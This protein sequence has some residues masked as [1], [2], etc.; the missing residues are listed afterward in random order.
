[1]APKASL[2]CLLFQI[3]AAKLLTVPQMCQNTVMPLP[4]PGSL[5]AMPFPPCPPGEQPTTHLL[6]LSS[7]FSDSREYNQGLWGSHQVESRSAPAFCSGLPV[8][9][10]VSHLD[11]VTGGILRSIREQA[12]ELSRPEFKSCQLCHLLAIKAT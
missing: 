2:L 7:P 4:L 8:P 10:V 5:P 6:R 1:M 9:G 11:A 12:S 3:S